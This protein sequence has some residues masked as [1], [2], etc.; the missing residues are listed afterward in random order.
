MNGRATRCGGTRRAEAV[1]AVRSRIQG[2]LS[3][4][5]TSP[6]RPRFGHESSVEPERIGIRVRDLASIGVRGLAVN[7]LPAL[8]TRTYGRRTGR[9]EKR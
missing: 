2:P 1:H 9:E 8:V 7:P 5:V 4:T 6:A 3:V